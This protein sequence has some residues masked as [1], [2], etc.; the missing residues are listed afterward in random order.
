V[1]SVSICLATGIGFG[2]YPA[3]QAAELDPI[4]ALHAE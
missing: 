3:R 1:L 4:K 2:W